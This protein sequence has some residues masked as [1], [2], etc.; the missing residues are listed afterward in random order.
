MKTKQIIKE[1][2][3]IIFILVAIAGVVLTIGTVDDCENEVTAR[4]IGL[5]AFG[6][7]L[8]VAALLS[9]GDNNN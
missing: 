6:I 7:G 5:A 8:A 1:L 3:R 9:G 2:F 4:G